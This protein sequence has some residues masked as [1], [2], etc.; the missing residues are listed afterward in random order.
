[1]PP[2]LLYFHWQH[3]LVYRILSIGHSVLFT[4]VLRA[5]ETFP[6]GEEEGRPSGAA[7]PE[8]WIGRCRLR[9]FENSRF[10]TTT[11]TKGTRIMNVPRKI[12]AWHRSFDFV[13]KY[14]SKKYIY[15]VFLSHQPR[16]VWMGNH[17]PVHHSKTVAGSIEKPPKQRKPRSLG[18][19][20]FPWVARILE[21]RE[22][23]K[24]RPESH[25]NGKQD[26]TTV[27][28]TTQLRYLW[29]RNIIVPLNLYNWNLVLVQLQHYRLVPVLKDM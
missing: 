21:G 14:K 9:Q 11:A 29:N 22:G 13:L 7:S 20:Q 2:E 17:P 16:I 19:T 28:I 3:Q 12:T 23:A 1:M 18:G 26:V 25:S 15:C 4:R 24:N 6:A 10:D 27:W 8:R 5:S